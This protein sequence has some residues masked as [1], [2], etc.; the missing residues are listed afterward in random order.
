MSDTTGAL[1]NLLLNHRPATLTYGVGCFGCK[2]F[3]TDGGQHRRHQIELIEA[4]FL[5]IPRSE[6]TGTEYGVRY[7]EQDG[8]T[9]TCGG[10]TLDA[11]TSLVQA[12]RGRQEDET[13]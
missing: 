7:A 13:E 3:F 12:I 11:A 4:E 10:L 9:E 1:I 2:G 5:V 8:T 6:I